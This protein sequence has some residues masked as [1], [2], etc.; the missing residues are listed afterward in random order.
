MDHGDSDRLD[1]NHSHFIL[2]KKNN[3]SNDDS[4]ANLKD[5][6][7]KEFKNDITNS[8][9]EEFLSLSIILN[10]K[11]EALKT[12][13]FSL[14]NNIPVL[15]IRETNG[16]ADLVSNIIDEFNKLSFDEKLLVGLQQDEQAQEKFLRKFTE[17]I[18]QEQIDSNDLKTIIHLYHKLRKEGK[19]ILINSLSFESNQEFESTI[20]ETLSLANSN[21]LT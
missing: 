9:N 3:E 14:N 21:C 8:L 2:V 5:W 6:S 18:E 11:T 15:L 20:L 13:I 12:I 19:T 10:G 7:T 16:A 17:E 1:K 4:T